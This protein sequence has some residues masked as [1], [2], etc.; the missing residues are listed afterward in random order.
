[1]AFLN[2]AFSVALL[3]IGFGFVIFWH[4]LG[5]FI[6]AKWVGIKVEQFAVGFGQAMFAWRKGMGLRWGSTNKEFEERLHAHAVEKWGKDVTGETELSSDQIK[7]AADEL[8]FSETEYRLNWI[9]LGGYVKMLGQDDLKANAQQD[10]PRAYNRQSI[11]ARM[12]VVSAGVIMNIILAAIGFM[13]V[14]MMGFNA[15]PAVVG[16]VQPLSPADKAGLQVNDRIIALDGRPQ[17]DFT[18]IALNVALLEEGAAAPLTYQR[19]GKEYSTTITPARMA[20]DPNGFLALGIQQP[21]EMRGLDPHDVSMDEEARNLV[22]AET[23]ALKPGDII[24]AVNGKALEVS[25]YSNEKKDAG[26]IARDYKTFDDALQSSRGQPVMITIKDGKTGMAQDVAV[27]PSFEMPFVKDGISFGGIEIRPRAES[28]LPGSPVVGKIEPGD[29]I[30]A[31]N[32]GDGAK[33]D[34]TW[35][36]VKKYFNDA[37]QNNKEVTITLLRGD[38]VV[39]IDHIVPAMKVGKDAEGKKTKGLGIGLGFDGGHAVVADV[40]HDSPA[41]RAGIAKGFTITAVNGQDV[42]SWYDVTAVL[43]DVKSGPVR[44]AFTTD[45]GEKKSAEVAM[46]SD[47]LAAIHSFRY[48]HP[49]G[50]HDRIEPRKTS[51]PIVAAR[52]GIAETRDFVLQFYLTIKRMVQG[53][54]SPG[55]MMGPLGIFHAGTKF[56]FKGLDW[57]IWFLAMISANLAVVNFLP[58]PIVDGGLFTFLILE[59]VMG[60]PLSPKA[61][62]VAQFVG[63]GLILGVFILVTFQDISRFF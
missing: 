40:Q 63:L 11:P 26:A 12:V 46:S 3:V 37:G 23:F 38:K 61:Q 25:D 45:T 18:K 7:R 51:D 35:D 16:G 41:D 9:P 48:T 8:G 21:S 54:V 31:V 57:L 20:G 39:T 28:V 15:P 33:T 62:Q 30:T 59:K 14:F 34:P 60:R 2:Q 36:D 27:H 4:E 24:T 43:K 55:N 42:G 17:N 5:H 1:M 32:W 53:S 52:W 10:D 56:A 13:I 50:L 22:P 47:D 58:I 29:V 6:A 49:L 19:N 44:F